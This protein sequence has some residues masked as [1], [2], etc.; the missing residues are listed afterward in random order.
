MLID[1]ILLHSTFLRTARAAARVRI[2]PASATVSENRGLWD[3]VDAIVEPFP[4]VEPFKE[5]PY[6]QARRL[7]DFVW[8]Y[9][10]RQPSRRHR[11]RCGCG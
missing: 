7:N 11:A 9:R 8:D 4:D 3:G 6:N 2:W 1:R 5:F 10:L